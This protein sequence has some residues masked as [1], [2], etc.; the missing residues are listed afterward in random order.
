MGVHRGIEEMYAQEF[1]ERRIQ[2]RKRNEQPNHMCYMCET[3]EELHYRIANSVVL[4]E[5]TRDTAC[6]SATRDMLA[7]RTLGLKQISYRFKAH[8]IER[9]YPEIL[10]VATLPEIKV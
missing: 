6:S 5:H 2:P 9:E 8:V 1:T 7:I 3:H 10:I 4:R